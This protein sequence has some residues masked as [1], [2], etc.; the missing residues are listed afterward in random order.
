MCV[1]IMSA[2]LDNVLYMSS[3]CTFMNDMEVFTKIFEGCKFHRFCNFL[4]ICKN[5][6]HKNQIIMVQ[7]GRV[8][9]FARIKSTKQIVRQIC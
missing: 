3:T 6:F 5:Y 1:C 8:H 9:K 2:T 4:S 7:D